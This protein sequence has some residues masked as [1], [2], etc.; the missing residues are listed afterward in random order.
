MDSQLVHESGLAPNEQL[1][2]QV[3]QRIV[4]W[5]LTQ[6]AILFLE[7]A[8]P[9]SFVASQGLLLCEPILGFL[10]GE[11]QVA[12]YAG[13]LGDRANVDRLIVRLEQGG[14]TPDHISEEQH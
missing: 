9:F 14:P 11:S 5:R 4:R 7:L 3:T 1:T 8:K 12:D 13:F 10:I 2:E 6:P